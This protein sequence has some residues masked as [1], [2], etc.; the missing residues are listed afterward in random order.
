MKFQLSTIIG[1]LLFAGLS[2][3]QK[4]DYDDSFTTFTSVY[5]LNNSVLSQN[6]AVK[7][8][9]HA[10]NWD[11]S[12][13]I[14]IPEGK[15]VFEF[16][17]KRDG[18]TVAQKTVDASAANPLTFM[19]FH[20]LVDAPLAFLDAKAEDTEPAAPDGFMKIKIANYTPDFIPF[21]KTDVVLNFRV[22]QGRQ[23][24]YVPVD[25]IEAV[26]R[27]LDTA[28]YRLVQRGTP[29]S[30]AEIY[31]LTFRDHATGEY[32]KN[33]GGTTYATH[34]TITPSPDKPKNVFTLFLTPVEYFANNLYLVKDD[35]YYYIDPKSVY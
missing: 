9:G 10:I 32:V 3:C 29:P 11:L 18:R 16:Y 30:G 34:M 20:P 33:A 28:V 25:T 23:Y 6:L 26:G 13:R 17:D 12:G 31:Y 22:Q 4:K 1:L 2:S 19:I 7:Y 27:N 15:G 5:F 24:V 21:E 8:E 35:I 14:D